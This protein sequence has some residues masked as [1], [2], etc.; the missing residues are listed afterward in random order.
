MRPGKN[1][2]KEVYCRC[3]EGHEAWVRVSHL[4]AGG[5]WNCR[6]CHC[7]RAAKQSADKIFHPLRHT[8]AYSAWTNMRH[9]VNHD[10]SY[11]RR[12]IGHCPT[13]ESFDAFLADMGQLPEGKPEPDRIN[14]HQ[15]YSKSNCRWAS[16][17]ENNANRTNL[18]MLTYGGR[19]MCIAH[20]E[21]HLGIPLE[22][23]RKKLRFNRPL[24]TIMAECGFQS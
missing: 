14:G 7:R 18:R 21:K 15:G 5:G 23:L 10:E 24:S 9:R 11:V 22:T 13:W 19:T 17:A 3:D 4:N 20:W 2:T 16:H 8:E 1:G 12:K 6:T